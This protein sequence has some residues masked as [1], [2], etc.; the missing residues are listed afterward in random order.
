[1]T[2]Y[3]LFN[4]LIFAAVAVLSFVAS[5][6][7]LA[8][9]APFNVWKEIVENRNVP[10]AIVAGAVALGLGWIIAAVMH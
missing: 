2:G 1:V 10:V 4:A 9:L 6:A 5:L 7:L 8:R 3:P